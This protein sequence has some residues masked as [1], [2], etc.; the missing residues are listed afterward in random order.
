[1]NEYL[2]LI[3]L[4]LSGWRLRPPRSDLDRGE[5]D[6]YRALPRRT[7]RRLTGDIAGMDPDDFLAWYVGLALRS[8]R[9][10]RQLRHARTYRRRDARARAEGWGSFHYY[11]QAVGW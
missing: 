9:R 6:A 7:V 11:R 8:I 5:Y 10:N 1:M 3:E 4:R 2:D